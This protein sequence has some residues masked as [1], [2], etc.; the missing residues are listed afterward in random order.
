MSEQLFLKQYKQLPENLK[1]ELIDFLEFRLMLV[2]GENI[3]SIRGI[4]VPLLRVE[5]FVRL[6]CTKP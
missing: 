4:Q 3:Y 1:Q 5:G 2:L 6:H